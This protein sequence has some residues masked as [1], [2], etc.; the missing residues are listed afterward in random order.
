MASVMVENYFSHAYPVTRHYLK[1][2][3]HRH[4]LRKI[5]ADLY[6]KFCECLLRTFA[7]FN[8]DDWT[9]ELFH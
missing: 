3:G 6:L 8:G 9:A 2:L 4:H 5:P 1:V 7:E